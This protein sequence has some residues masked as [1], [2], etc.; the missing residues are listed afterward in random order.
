M[1]RR[2]FTLIEISIALLLL[3]IIAGVSL[4]LLLQNR[5]SKNIEIAKREM[6]TYKRRL[7]V[8]YQGNNTIPVHKSDFT[9]P[10]TT[11]QIP[12]RFTLDPVSGIPYRYYADNLADGNPIYVD[13][14]SI[15]DISAVIISAG[16]NGKFDGENATP[17]DK[18]FQS[19]G[20]GDFDDILIS[21]SQGELMA[22]PT[23]CVSYRVT[24]RN[25]SG[26]TIYVFPSKTNSTYQTITNGQQYTW[27]SLYPDELVLISSQTAFSTISTN[28]FVPKSY[29]SNGNCIIEI[30][31]NAIRSSVPVF[32]TDQN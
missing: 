23:L 7:I 27:N 30:T 8:Y 32:T 13:G 2:G 22:S 3:G 19:T 1:K 14:N 5:K 21:V 12:R 4:P 6:E 17:A 29:D 26:S 11:L 31:V 28:S 15:G 25:A 18:R 9:L 16:P 10:D 24:V 20:T